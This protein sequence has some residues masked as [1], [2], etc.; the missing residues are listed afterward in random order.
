MNSLKVGDKRKWIDVDDD[1][2]FTITAIGET[3]LLYSYEN[4]GEFAENISRILNGTTPY[5]EPAPVR[6]IVGHED[7][8]DGEIYTTYEGSRVCRARDER[9]KDFKRIELSPEMFGREL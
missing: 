5:T 4:E 9:I 6:K 1:S 7:L 3:N 8:N 2:F